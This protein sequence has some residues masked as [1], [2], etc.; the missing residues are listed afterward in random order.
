MSFSTIA[1]HNNRI[2]I[3]E[4]GRILRPS[5]L[6]NHGMHTGHILIDQFRKQRTSPQVL[7]LTYTMTVVPRYKNNFLLALG[8]WLLLRAARN[9][10]AHGKH[11][12][13]FFYH[14]NV[15]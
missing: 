12:N 7:M 9:N 10:R 14:V 6:G 11:G 3:I 13:H 8:G 2:R 5:L 1:V 15:I 4:Y